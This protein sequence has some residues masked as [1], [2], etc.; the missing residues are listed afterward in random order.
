MIAPN[1]DGRRFRVAGS[2]TVF[3]FTQRGAIV[4]AA[5]AGGDVSHGH[6]LAIVDEAGDLD[7]RFHHVTTAMQFRAGT[8]RFLYARDP[9]NN[10]I[11]YEGAWRLE[12]L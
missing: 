9:V 11:V 1:L 2:P 7:A 10:R 12:E 5:Y 6:L 3:V 8:S 4:W